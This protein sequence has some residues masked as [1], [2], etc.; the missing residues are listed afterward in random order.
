MVAI[1]FF[2][3]LIVPYVYVMRDNTW[4]IFL[5]AF[6]AYAAAVLSA[7]I[8]MALLFAA[9][10]GNRDW[11]LCMNALVAGLVLG[12]IPALIRRAVGQRGSHSAHVFIVAWAGLLVLVLIALHFGLNVPLSVFASAG[13]GLY[14]I[15]ALTIHFSGTRTAVSTA[16]A[17]KQRDAALAANYARKQLQRPHPALRDAWLPHLRALG[18]DGALKTWRELP[19]HTFHAPAMQPDNLPPFTGI[20][21]ENIDPDWIDAL[22]VLTGDEA[23]EAAEDEARAAKG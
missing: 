10:Q 20:L 23:R 15:W 4:S 12:V 2:S 21:R 14:W 8:F 1:N 18:L 6:L 16:L 7:S 13:L 5:P 19:R 17:R 22:C 11:R 9:F 3:C